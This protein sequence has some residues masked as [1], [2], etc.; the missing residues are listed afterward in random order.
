MRTFTNSWR[1][2]NSCC[3]CQQ[4][5]KHLSPSWRFQMSWAFW[6]TIMIFSPYL[7]FTY[8][9]MWVLTIFFLQGYPQF[10]IGRWVYGRKPCPCCVLAA[11]ASSWLFCVPRLPPGGAEA[12]HG[13][14]AGELQPGVTVLFVSRRLSFATAPVWGD[15]SRGQTCIKPLNQLMFCYSRQLVD[16]SLSSDSLMQGSAFN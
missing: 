15:D 2:I 11:P 3:E 13:A 4:D 9:V 1:E 8:R 10:P 6:R 7:C 12:P 5:L 16:P 14:A